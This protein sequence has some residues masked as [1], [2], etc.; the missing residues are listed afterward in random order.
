MVFWD[1]AGGE[2]A[3]RRVGARASV[4]L[5]DTAAICAAPV[6]VLLAGGRRATLVVSVGVRSFAGEAG[7]HAIIQLSWSS[8]S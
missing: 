1:L 8:T 4:S 3:W 2:G 7:Y 5:S 6:W